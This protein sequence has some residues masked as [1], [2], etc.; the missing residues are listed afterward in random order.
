MDIPKIIAEDLLKLKDLKNL[1]V[2]L[3]CV[4]VFCFGIFVYDN[5]VIK[6]QEKQ[7]GIL[8]NVL[9]LASYRVNR[10]NNKTARGCLSLTYPPKTKNKYNTPKEYFS[11]QHLLNN[12][13]MEQTSSTADMNNWI[14]DSTDK[15]KEEI[16]K[17]LNLLKSVV[18]DEQYNLLQKS[19]KQ[20]EEYKTT[21][22]DFINNLFFSRN[23]GGNMWGSLFRLYE[24]KLIEDR[25]EVLHSLYDDACDLQKVKEEA[26]NEN[27]VN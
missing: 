22:L 23:P 15:W 4:L 18:S 10:L 1:V 7:I 21:E 16:N 11:M 19:Q 14:A 9:E 27:S 5:Y 6:E 25:V 12:N 24:L 13:I 2:F 8:K 20:W 3:L 26:E 17:N